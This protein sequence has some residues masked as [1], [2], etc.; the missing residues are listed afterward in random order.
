M[1]IDEAQKRTF[2]LQSI[3]NPS[4]IR[5]EPSQGWFS[6]RLC[7]LS[8]YRELLYF[9]AWR[10]VKVRY[11]QTAIGVG[12]A[13]LQP[14][15]TMIV[16][17]AI[18]GRFAQIPSDGLPYPLFSFSALIPWTYFSTALNRSIASVV[19]ESHL[20]SKVYFPRLILPLAGTL[21][22]LVDF[23]I[24]LIVLLGMMVWYGV[25]ITWRLL[26]LPAFL[27]FALLTALAAGLWL[28]AINVRYR[29]VGHG[30]PF[31]IQIWMFCSPV[32]Y[33]VSLIPEKYRLLY[34]LNPMVGVIEGFRWFLLGTAH[35]DFSVMTI[36]AV[37]VF[38][39]LTGGVIFFKNMERTFADV[40]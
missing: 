17:T 19:T 3:V 24:S 38:I 5:I 1:T 34:S 4:V 23:S 7:E 15:I 11:K 36:S 30:V 32:F 22:A 14:I 9:L 27:L 6:L 33:P 26:T 37:V 16:F 2:K 35:P 39:I 10:D 21:A 31:L 40:V 29:D 8:E 20:I 25:D 12:W 28:S 18:F 13:V